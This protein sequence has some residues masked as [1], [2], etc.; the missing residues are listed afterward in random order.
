MT[1]KIGKAAALGA[2]PYTYD[3]ETPDEEY[4][5][6]AHEAFVTD[7]GVLM[8]RHEDGQIFRAVSPSGWVSVAQR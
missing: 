5:V 4:T 8:F 1:A 7:G 3:I 2:Q 6:I